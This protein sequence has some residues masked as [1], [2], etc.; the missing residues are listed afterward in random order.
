MSFSG[1]LFHFCCL[2]IVLFPVKIQMGPE[3]LSGVV[4]LAACFGLFAT[5]HTLDERFSSTKNNEY[6]QAVQFSSLMAQTT[7]IRIP[8]VTLLGLRDVGHCV[9]IP[10]HTSL[11]VQT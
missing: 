3:S 4:G 11:A 1:T 10:S 6:R 7:S 9:S 8:V 5:R 2:A